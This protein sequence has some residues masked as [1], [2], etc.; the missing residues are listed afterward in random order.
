MFCVAAL[1]A[2][3]RG[4]AVAVAATA[5]VFVFLPT[6]PAAAFAAQTP[7]AGLPGAQSFVTRAELDR[8][9]ARFAT[10]AE[11][12]ELRA[13]LETLRARLSELKS[14][15]AGVKARLDGGEASVGA[16]RQPALRGPQR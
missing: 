8:T 1:S 13:Q 9:L 12:D 3:R 11:V 4:P 10:K 15:V 5:A 14:Q 7:A 2:R 6:T 16:Q